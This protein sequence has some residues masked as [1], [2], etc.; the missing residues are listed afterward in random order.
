[1]LTFTKNTILIKFP[2]DVFKLFNKCL[3]ILASQ[4]TESI[5]IEEKNLNQ[6]I[7]RTSKS[8]NPKEVSTCSNCFELLNG[9]IN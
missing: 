8:Q 7:I 1:M 6:P 3:T 9:S 2:V 4:K 5:T